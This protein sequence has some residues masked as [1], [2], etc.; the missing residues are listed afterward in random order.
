MSSASAA[1]AGRGP[2]SAA[3]SS[4]VATVDFE[5]LKDCQ[6]ILWISQMGFDEAKA[7]LKGRGIDGE[8]SLRNGP[9][10]GGMHETA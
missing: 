10:R 4:A 1:A 7:L 9:A 5:K 2:S 8:V 6:V 3:A